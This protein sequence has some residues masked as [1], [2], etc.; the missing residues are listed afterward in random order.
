MQKINWT[1]HVRNVKV[2][3]RVKEER[4]ILHRIKR[5]KAN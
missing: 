5:R 2:L 4:Y 1:E 3:Q